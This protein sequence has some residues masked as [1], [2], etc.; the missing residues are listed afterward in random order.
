MRLKRLVTNTSTFRL[1]K[2]SRLFSRNML[3]CCL[4]LL[5]LL[6]SMPATMAASQLMITPTR[7]VFSEKMRKASVTIINNGDS[8]GTYRISMVNKRMNVNGGFEDVKEAAPG[9]LFSDKMIRF[10]PRQVVLEPGKTQVVRLGLRKP[11]DLKDGE[12]RSHMLFRAIP[13]D[14]GQSVK[15]LA[16]PSAGVTVSLTAIVGISIPVIVRHGQTNADVAIASAKYLPRQEG[17]DSSSL[18]IE[19]KRSGNQSVYGDFLAEFI[20]SEG[21]RK[22]ISQVNGVA[23]YAPGTIRRL[24]LPVKI[25][26]GLELVNGT[27]QVFYRNQVD[28]GGAVL[29]QAQIKMP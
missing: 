13:E 23:I 24:R 9:E 27:I 20:T 3:T 21:E 28:Q 6:S 8:T 7:I 1:Y 17:E 10:S 19:L 11:S 22:V 25:P 18:A 26:L 29:A 14:I 15:A 2:E 12:Y 4:V 16:D 5:I